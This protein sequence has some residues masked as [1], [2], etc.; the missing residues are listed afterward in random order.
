MVGE[1]SGWT[2]V[3]IALIIAL[4]GFAL[5]TTAFVLVIVY[6]V[7]G[8]GDDDDAKDGA[9]GLQGSD[10]PPGETGIQGVPGIQ[11]SPGIQGTVGSPGTAGAPGSAGAAGPPGTAGVACWDTNQNGLCDL[12]TEDLD[13]NGR[14]NTDDCKPLNVRHQ[15]FEGDCPCKCAVAERECHGETLVWNDTGDAYICSA[16]QGK[17]LSSAIERLGE[18]YGDCPRGENLQSF[19]TCRASFGLSNNDVGRG[20]DMGSSVVDP[21]T[22][23]DVSISLVNQPT[24]GSYNIQLYGSGDPAED[25]VAKMSL[26]CTLAR[27]VTTEALIAPVEDCHIDGDQ[28]IAIGIEN[29]TDDTITQF[30]L[31]ITYRKRF[32]DCN[33]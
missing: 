16:S 14:C 23:T 10:G 6:D 9:P 21:I 33:V 25:D 24:G 32:D 22:V 26:L 18:V 13:A 1:A 2:E 28:F 27:R 19:K 29:F 30:T 11:G 15:V 12:A 20:L 7:A 5:A 8:G 17:Y 31:S 3:R 4:L